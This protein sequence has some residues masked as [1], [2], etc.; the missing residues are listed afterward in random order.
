MGVLVIS[1]LLRKLLQRDEYSAKAI[2]FWLFLWKRI[3]LSVHSTSLSKMLLLR[4]GMR[5]SCINLLNWPIWRVQGGKC[6]SRWLWKTHKIIT[7]TGEVVEGQEKRTLRS[8]EPVSFNIMNHART[9]CHRLNGLTFLRLLL[10]MIQI[11]CNKPY[12]CLKENYNN[13][14]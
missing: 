14:C 8:D 9:Q 2:I 1:K 12:L 7:I 5:S 11:P 13:A 4:E 10:S 6:Y 3:L